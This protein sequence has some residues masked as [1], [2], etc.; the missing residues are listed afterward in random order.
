VDSLS[1]FFWAWAANVFWTALATRQIRHWIALGTLI[2]MGFLSKFTNGLQLVCIGLFLLWSKPHRAL[3]LSRQTFAMC[4]AFGLAS[5]PIRVWN[6]QT[7]WVHVQALHSRS[8]VRYS[9][10]IHPL[11]LL[12]FIGGEAG[13]ISPL[14]M[15]GMVIAVVGM[16][17]HHRVEERV[18]FLL[19]QFL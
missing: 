5:L 9:F 10:G 3:L 15:I 19:S 14:L 2:G 4:L 7:G 1:V 8:G 11:E 12:R 13:V 17:R 16:T 6:I 18:Q